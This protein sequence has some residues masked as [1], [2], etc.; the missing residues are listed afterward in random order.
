MSS[1][2]VARLDWAGEVFYRR[3]MSKIDDHGLYDARLA[4]LRASLYPLCLDRV[5][6]SD[7]ERWL[8]ACEAAELLETYVV[9]GKP[10]LL[11]FNTGWDKRS[12]PKH[13]FPPVNSR[14]Q[15]P[16]D[17]SPVV[18]VVVVVGDVC[19]EQRSTPSAPVAHLP[20]VDGSEYAISA[21][22]IEGWR[23]A[24]P[25]VDVKAHLL[26]MREW[27]LSNP[28]KRKT[29]RGIRRFVTDWLSREQD[30]GGKVIPIKPRDE[31]A[32]AV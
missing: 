23:Q 1:E 4:I 14:K 29:R 5:A 12:K 26:R 20:L 28:R 19:T 32:N 16:T 27:C 22:D 15:P 18:D 3:L 17:V 21:A 13:P 9:D 31:F 24:Y 30:R 6:E 2:K 7:V 8:L 11:V 10:Y 25:A